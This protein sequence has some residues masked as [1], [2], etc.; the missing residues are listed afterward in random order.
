MEVE[1]ARYPMRCHVCGATDQVR[2]VVADM[3]GDEKPFGSQGVLP[4]E[5][6]AP[7]G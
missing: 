7:E 1:I 4:T 5:R 3:C 2:V 6:I